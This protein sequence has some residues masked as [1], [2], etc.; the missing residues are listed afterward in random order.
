[1]LYQVSLILSVT[2][3]AHGTFIGDPRRNITCLGSSYDM[4]LPIR[5]D[6]V[7]LNQLTMQQLCA[8]RAYGGAGI[9]RAMGGWCSKGLEPAYI[10]DEYGGDME[11][12][13]DD[14]MLPT[15]TGV[16]FDATG[17]E[18]TNPPGW[19]PNQPY[20]ND[21][22]YAGCLNRCFCSWELD[23]LTIQPKREVPSNADVVT[24]KR[25]ESRFI[26]IKLEIVDM[27]GQG[28]HPGFN[29]RVPDDTEISVLQVMEDLGEPNEEGGYAKTHSIEF[30]EVLELSL[31]PGN[32][33]TCEGDLPSFSLPPPYTN[34]DFRTAQ[35]LCAVQWFR[36]LS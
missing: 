33:I 31:D 6:G 28:Y 14:G 24:R 5:P 36:G 3:L 25:D 17:A 7:D 22:L 2:L 9:S 21:R 1:M 13:Q 27:S 26:E 15:L 8:K 19:A 29:N 11:W 10:A 23:D 30:P 32:D 35:E 4:R 12:R 34:A 20:F 16:S 18:D